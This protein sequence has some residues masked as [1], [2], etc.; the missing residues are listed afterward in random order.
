MTIEH[1][2][3]VAQRD[4]FLALAEGHELMTNFVNQNAITLRTP[5]IQR[6]AMVTNYAKSRLEDFDWASKAHPVRAEFNLQH[7]GETFRFRLHRAEPTKGDRKGYDPQQ[8]KPTQNGVTANGKGT[9]PDFI[10]L[11][12]ADHNGLIDVWAVT[13]LEALEAQAGTQRA[14]YRTVNGQR[15]GTTYRLPHVVPDLAALEGLAPDPVHKN[16]D[17]GLDET[18]ADAS[19]A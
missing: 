15:W 10:L 6:S 9:G 13:P 17:V 18:D 7:G 2:L 14:S 8:L 4:I 19:G 11:W 16:V 12:V 1:A 5:G 3:E